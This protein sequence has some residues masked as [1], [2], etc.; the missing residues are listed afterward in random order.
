MPGLKPE[1][2]TKPGHKAPTPMPSTSTT[3]TIETEAKVGFGLLELFA[4]TFYI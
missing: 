3:S 2:E 4:T 1:I